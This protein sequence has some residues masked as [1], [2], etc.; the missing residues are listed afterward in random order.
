MPLHGVVPQADI[1]IVLGLDSRLRQVLR[2][3]GV[4]I[5]MLVAGE[6]AQHHARKALN[7]E[8]CPS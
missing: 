6:T 8:L 2:S 1:G 3:A 7:C 4:E 5:R